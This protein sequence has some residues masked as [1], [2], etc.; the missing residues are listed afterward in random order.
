MSTPTAEDVVIPGHAPLA[1]CLIMP[2]GTP[3]A[4]CVIHAATGTPAGFYRAF[5]DWLAGERDVAVLIYDYRDF[6]RSARGPIRHSRATM[7]DW[8]INDQQTARDWLAARLPDI[9]IWVIGHSLGG[10]MLPFQMGLAGISRV[11]T[12]AS[13]AVHLMDHPWPYRA[14]AASFWF[15]VGAAAH[16][17][18]GYVPGR[19]VGLPGD[20]AIPGGVFTQWRRWCTRAGFHAADPNLPGPDP[21]ALTCPTRM[22]AVADDALCPPKSVWRLMRAYPQAPKRQLVLRPTDEPIGHHGVFRRRH[23][24]LWPELVD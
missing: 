8:G 11:V 22:V 6:G 15:G 23:A 10:M 7:S 5:A 18:L 4:A 19:L 20:V 2:G 1:G 3:R 21:S 17:T 12:V 13:G 24:A 14:F 9:P 16:R